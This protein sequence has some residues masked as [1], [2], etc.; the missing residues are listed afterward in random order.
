MGYGLIEN[1]ARRSAWLSARPITTL[2]LSFVAIAAIIAAAL[3]LPH[4]APK[5][6]AL[7]EARAAQLSAAWKD[8]PESYADKCHLSGNRALPGACLYGA[9]MG[10]K[11]AILLGDSHA[12][13]WLGALDEAGRASRYRIANRTKSSCPAALGVNVWLPGRKS[14]TPGCRDFINNQVKAI[15]INPPDVVFMTSTYFYQMAGDERGEVLLEAPEGLDALTLGTAKLAEQIIASGTTL[16]LIRDTPQAFRDY[17]EC[18]ERGGGKSCE[19]PKAQA[20]P[21]RDPIV[22]AYDRLSAQ[23]KGRAQIL[24]L[25]DQVCPS[26]H[27]PLETGQSGETKEPKDFGGIIIYRDYHHITDSYSRSLSKPFE[28]ILKDRSER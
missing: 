27:C 24:D 4:I 20:L 19:R 11:R 22:Q 7:S 16:I 2:I 15:T 23:N 14:V 18:L 8:L 5:P 25:T 26:F 9:P 28:Q 1:P 21:A 12:A 13:Q 6:A 3:A 17:R 10:S